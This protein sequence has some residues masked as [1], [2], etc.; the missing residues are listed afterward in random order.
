MSVMNIERKII[1]NKVGL[2]KPINRIRQA[3]QGAKSFEVNVA[4]PIPVAYCL[5]EPTWP[6]RTAKSASSKKSMHTIQCS[7]RGAGSWIS[8]LRLETGPFCTAAEFAAL[9]GSLMQWNRKERSL[10]RQ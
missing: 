8:I 6:E 3:E 10:M 2:L 5:L 4:K 1:K 7:E 9:R